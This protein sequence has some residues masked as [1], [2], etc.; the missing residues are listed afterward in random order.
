MTR[1]FIPFFLFVTVSISLSADISV[2]TQ[3]F[4]LAERLA[5][6]LKVHLTIEVHG[7]PNGIADAQEH[8]R[9]DLMLLPDQGL[10]KD[11]TTE[12]YEVLLGPYLQ[13]FNFTYL[14]TN[15]SLNL[16]DD[17][18]GL[19]VSTHLT[20]NFLLARTPFPL[21]APVEKA[22]KVVTIP[23]TDFRESLCSTQEGWLR[24]NIQTHSKGARD[25]F[26]LIYVDQNGATCPLPK[27]QAS[28]CVD[29]KSSLGNCL[30]N[31]AESQRNGP[32]LWVYF[33]MD[34]PGVSSTAS[35]GYLFVK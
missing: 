21:V 12:N 24:K 7:T 17:C 8:L 20:E 31:L 4:G 35:S 1:L 32:L 13:H 2:N 23:A 34:T 5:E 27:P 3:L 19:P 29:P 6:K 26:N 22:G 30:T 16:V 18:L 14:E 9:S 11:I 33:N 25:V 10:A 28:C 15:H